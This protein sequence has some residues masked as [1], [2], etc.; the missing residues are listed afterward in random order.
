VAQTT[1]GIKPNV[2]HTAQHVLPLLNPKPSPSMAQGLRAALSF[3]PRP[4]AR[5]AT[6]CSARIVGVRGRRRGLMVV[7]AGGPPSTNVLILAFVLPL[8]LFVGTLITA[9]RVADDLDERFLREVRNG[10]RSISNQ[11]TS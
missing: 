3:V 4:G 11:L 6:P 8:S 5:T 10:H 7:Q 9:A 1:E 2:E